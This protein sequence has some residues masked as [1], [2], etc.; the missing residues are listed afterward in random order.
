MH[1]RDKKPVSK[2]KTGKVMKMPEG[3]SAKPGKASPGKPVSRKKPNRA[4]HINLKESRVTASRNKSLSRVTVV[5]FGF[6]LIYILQSLITFAFKPRTVI[7]RIVPGSV[8]SPVDLTGIIIRD[9]VVYSSSASGSVRFNVAENERIKKGEIVCYIQDSDEVSRINEELMDVNE[10]L[11]KMQANRVDIA[12]FNSDERRLNLLMKN[13]LDNWA[14]KMKT[15]DFSS[16]YSL[17]DSLSVN[18][19]LR[20]RSILS[21]N[22]NTLSK[23]L[24][25]RQMYEEELSR[26]MTLITSEDSGIVSRQL[27]GYEETYTLNIMAKLPKELI[28]IKNSP[29]KH[30][31]LK[32]A[33]PDTPLFKVIR[34]NNWYVASYIPNDIIEGWQE[35]DNKVISVDTYAGLPVTVER[36]TA[37]EGNE[38]YVLFKCT[39]YL[40]EYLDSRQL[41]FRVSGDKNEGLKIPRSAVAT[42]TLI[43]VPREFVSIDD[44]QLKTATFI[45]SGSEKI[46]LTYT[47]IDDEMIYMDPA[48][49][50]VTLGKEIQDPANAEKKFHLNGLTEIMGVYRVNYGTA[51]FRKVVIN[52]APQA[53]GYYILDPGLNKGLQEK[54]SIVQDASSVTEGDIIW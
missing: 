15:G 14:G 51:D 16:L 7:E 27:D 33:E 34:S 44:D 53:A 50:E 52:D 25:R 45:K 13:M 31:A 11:L 5:F 42:K 4:K 28:M 36:I 47:A 23:Q 3:R 32:S 1:T 12:D 41:R 39:R 2:N 29:D 40:E 9:E 22:S 17:K 24:T 8:T 18:V 21:D 38:S 37:E 20:N 48:N 30:P 19:E 43:P 46:K 49:I 6:V 10:E 35:K 54:D 26:H